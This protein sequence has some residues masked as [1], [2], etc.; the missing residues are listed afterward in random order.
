LNTTINT[1]N[2]S[3][4]TGD[5]NVSQQGS[6]KLADVQAAGGV[7]VAAANGDIT[8]GNVSAQN[9]AT[10]TASSGAIDDDG[11]TTT[12]LTATT[13][14]LLARS[15]GSPSTLVGT[16]V[17]SKLRLGTDVT[18][19]VATS[20]AGGVYINQSQGL[21]SAN[22]HATGGNTGNIELLTA[23]GDLNIQS[24]AA[25][26][27][28]LLAAGGN[29]YALP[30]SGTI[31]AQAAELRAGGADLNAGHIGTLSRPLELQLS[32][33]ETLRMFVPQTVNPHDS[34][35]GPATLPTAGVESTLGLFAA[36]NGLAVDAGFG[37]FQGLGE[38]QFT[39]QAE[40]LVHSIQ[41]QTATVQTVLGLDWNS[42]NPNVSLF[43]K[44]D[45][46]V[47]LPGDQ[48]DE[49]AGASDAS[50]KCAAP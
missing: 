48:R 43:G 40:L 34:A 23:T 5:I 9:N 31:T 28:L 47:C 3:A 17:D 45:P 13:A 46:S 41:N 38:S 8:V 26:G 35:S 37:Q 4:S 6:L 22:V 20:T 24:M 42:F 29:I 25:S 27:S 16:T 18:N 33:G 39:S 30:G 2:A 12:R 50:Q 44:L 14:T 11:D 32:P 1:L 21:A 15:I 19:L 7:N 49:E 10:L 36:P